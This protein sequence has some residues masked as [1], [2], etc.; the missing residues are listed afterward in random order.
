M[1][2]LNWISFPENKAVTIA[3]LSSSLDTLSFTSLILN[4]PFWLEPSTQVLFETYI[5]SIFFV[6]SRLN[7]MYWS[8]SKSLN[9]IY[10]PLMW[11]GLPVSWSTY[12]QVW[13][14]QLKPPCGC[15]IVFN[16]Y[17]IEAFFLEYLSQLFMVIF[18][19]NCFPSY[20]PTLVYIIPNLPFWDSGGLV[21]FK[22][23]TPLNTICSHFTFPNVLTSVL[24]FTKL[25]ITAYL[26]LASEFLLGTSTFGNVLIGCA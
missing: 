19:S 24:P 17:E 21:K 4:S 14:T 5:L 15:P 25:A 26:L 22:H 12:C 18:K 10:E 23:G 9:V 8:P 1:P 3:N 11:A 6:V 16:T 2:H 7:W 20:V 13:S